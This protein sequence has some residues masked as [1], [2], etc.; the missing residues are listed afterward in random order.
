MI[1]SHWKLIA[2]SATELPRAHLRGTT[3]PPAPPSTPKA[4]ESFAIP[5]DSTS[6]EVWMDSTCHGATTADL[7]NTSN[8]QTEL[9]AMV[10]RTHCRVPIAISLASGS[11][12]DRQ[13]TKGSRRRH[14]LAR[15]LTIASARSFE[16][17]HSPASRGDQTGHRHPGLHLYRNIYHLLRPHRQ[18]RCQQGE[19]VPS[20]PQLQAAH[21]LH[22]KRTGYPSTHGTGQLCTV[23]NAG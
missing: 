12:V 21:S 17:V 22:V 8:S 3:S 20:C 11:I 13:S 7:G 19:A 10:C 2:P 23:H 6:S 16:I 5:S 15:V 14:S 18:K 9:P 1:R 4:Q